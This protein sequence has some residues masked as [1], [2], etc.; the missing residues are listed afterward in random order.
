ML[1]G[2]RRDD[3]LSRLEKDGR[4]LVSQLSGVFGVS[5]E[6]I[7]RDLEKLEAEGFARRCYGGASFTGG[8][9]LPY[10]VRKKSNVS[11]KRRIAA[12]VAE[13]ISDGDS[14]MLDDSSTAVFVAQ[15]LPEKK[16]LT[17][18]TNSLEITLLLAD[19]ADWNVLLSGGA[20][21][22]P[23]LSLSGAKAESF[24]TDYHTDWAVISCAGVDAARG[25]S[26]VAEDSARIKRAMLRSAER[27]VLAADSRKIGR[28][29]FASVCRPDEL[30]TV[31]TD[32]S[33][34]DSR[35]ASF[36]RWDVP[37]LFVP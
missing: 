9:E 6:T 27:T 4:V 7:R 11:A 13:L 20:L 21:K 17:V 3:I 5:E 19:R 30:Y 23:S 33:P 37:F 28:R 26:D 34:E 2:E 16:H 29:A 18:I 35:A 1:A 32:L 25:V 22:L 8:R 36:A 24:L 14:V 12:A 15:A 10:N 31:V